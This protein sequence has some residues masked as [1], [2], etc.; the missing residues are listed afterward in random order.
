MLR[1]RYIAETR[2]VTETIFLYKETNTWKNQE[3][4]FKNLEKT[5]EMRLI[6]VLP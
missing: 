2:E 1:S 4:E 3:N 5:Q 6:T